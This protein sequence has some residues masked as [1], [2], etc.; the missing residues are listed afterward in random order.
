MYKLVF[1]FLFLSATAFAQSKTAF[2]KPALYFD[3]PSVLQKAGVKNVFCI[4]KDSR[5]LIWIGTDNGIF[6]YDGANTVYKRHIP[7]DTTSIPNNSIITIT[8]DKSNHLWLGTKAGVACINPYNLKCKIYR[9]E[10]HNL[11]GNFDNKVFVADD[12]TIWTGNSEG[13]FLFN[14]QKNKFLKVWKN[15][16]DGKAGTAYV[17]ALIQWK[18]DTL[19][20]GTF[21]DLVLL[22]TKSFGFRRITPLNTDELVTRLLLDDHHRL[23]I[24]TW[25][26]GCIVSN[27]SLTDFQRYQWEKDIPLKEDNV[28]WS[29]TKT[30]SGTG[31]DVWIA[32]GGKII[33]LREENTIRFDAATIYPVD[34]KDDENMVTC[35]MADDENYVWAGGNIIQ[36][37]S[38]DRNRFQTFPFSLKGAVVNMQSL[39]INRDSC[40]A[41]S[42]WH[43]PQGLLFI[44][45]KKETHRSIDN[46]AP[47]DP[48]GV[49]ISGVAADKLNRIWLSSLAGVYLLDDHLNII[50]DLAKTTNAK[51][52]LSARKTNDILISNDTVWIA[53]YRGGIDLYDLSVHKLKHFTDHDGT[54]LMDN[55]ISRLFRDKSGTIWICGD[56]YFYK[57]LS[58]SARFK[59]Y[60]FSVEHSIYSPHDV[61]E[62]PDGNL[63]IATDIGLIYF[64]TATE[65][66]FKITTPLLEKEE[67]VLSVAVDAR[68]NVWYLTRGHLVRYEVSAKKFTLFGEEDGLHPNDLEFIRTF[69]GSEMLLAENRRLLKFNPGNWQKKL[70][71]PQLLMNVIQINDSILQP[72]KPVT[73]LHL[74]YNQN[75]IYFEFDGINYVKPEQNQYA[76]KL[77]GIDKDWIVSAKNFTSYTNLSPGNYVFHVKVANYAG[78]WS[79]EQI[80]QIFIEPP[81]W[82][83]WW[84]IGLEII[85]F[86]ALFVFIIRYISQRNLR[87]RILKLEKEQA[88]EKERN[89]IARDMHDNLGS[90]LTKIAILSEVAKTQLQHRE[91]ASAQL[92]KI[93]Y[94]SRELVDN[95]QDIIWVLN[96]KNDSLDNLAAY[97]REYALKFFEATNVELQF[98]YPQQIPSVKLS[99][100]QRRNIF[101]VIKET[102]NN[103]AK[104][105]NCTVIT[106]KLYLQKN[107]LRMEIKDNGKGFDLSAVRHFANGIS[108]MKLR[109][110]QVSGSYE[111]KSCVNEGT[112]TCLAMH[113]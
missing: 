42:Q 8:E 30:S 73:E 104:Y 39:V 37:F 17:T 48:Y 25:G 7:G 4:F 18:R 84:F 43:G 45:E 53:C 101:M 15:E 81:F 23:W 3:Q 58:Q 33:K 24:G 26:G 106:I 44:D 66:F 22:N 88:V 109:M 75:K 46:I 77:D 71:P 63:V 83:T 64:N 108:N 2:D 107:N 5:K 72:S 113:L 35:L 6:R 111:I 61:A 34:Q 80:I 29:L 89:R 14:P 67:E 9:K 92:E 86:G 87:M 40:I 112:V 54:G 85:I 59:K 10:L 16:P 65:N 93:S 76:Y 110:E 103:S 68:G 102:L 51:D 12:G 62:L 70:P 11:D 55:L 21:H 41:V 19:A 96:P 38:A 50:K 94:S 32:G 97:I 91:A 20:F 74:R 105:A 100:E 36:K 28:V 98:E 13:L 56:T 57:Y 82:K 69:D 1:I 95:L 99:E 47:G 49:D 52:V 79:K 90:G 31:S 78:E 27:P 60:D